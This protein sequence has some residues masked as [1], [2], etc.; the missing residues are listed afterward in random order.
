MGSEALGVLCLNTN[1]SVV[2][3]EAPWE[4]GCLGEKKGEGPHVHEI[5]CT[6]ESAGKKLESCTWYKRRVTVKNGLPVGMPLTLFIRTA[7]WLVRF[8]LGENHLLF[9][10]K[11]NLYV[12]AADTF[13]KEF[14]AR[15]FT[16]R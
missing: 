12:W 5:F 1:L 2:P 4:L 10:L 6:F 11:L 14:L 9:P 8:R 7:T 13:G 15:Q 3:S 16:N